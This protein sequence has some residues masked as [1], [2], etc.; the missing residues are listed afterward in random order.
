VLLTISGVLATVAAWHMHRWIE[1]PGITLG[2]HF[3]QQWRQLVAARIGIPAALPV[4]P[5]NSNS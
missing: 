1:I 3:A 5:N 4:Q 2:K